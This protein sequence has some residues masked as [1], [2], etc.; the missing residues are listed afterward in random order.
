ML[1]VSG[2]EQLNTS[3]DQRM[4][5]ISS[6][7]SAYSR[8]V[9]CSPSNV[10]ALVDMLERAAGR[11]E[12]VPQARRLGLGLQFLDQLER[13]PAVAAR[14]S[15]SYSPQLAARTWASMNSRTR[16]RKKDWRS[17]RSKSIVAASA[18]H[19]RVSFQNGLGLAA[20]LDA[21]KGKIDGRSR[22]IPR[23]NPRLAGGQLP[24]RNAHADARRKRTPAGAGGNFEFQSPAQKQWL[25]VMASRGWTVPD[26]PKEYGG[27]GLSPAETKILKE[28]MARDRRRVAADQ[29]RH[30]DARAGAA[31]VSAT[32]SRRS[33]S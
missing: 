19:G 24:G 9:S 12:Q 14:R 27:G 2:A 13:L 11:H 8:L 28:E 33:A 23:R 10:E 22:H 5:P 16:S 21:V 4:R 17:V 30:F 26:W 31:Q 29:L 7:H 25:D 18:C 32:R 6:A 20:R 1:P 3:A 15:L